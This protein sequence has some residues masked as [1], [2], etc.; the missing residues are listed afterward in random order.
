MARKPAPIPDPDHPDEKARRRRL[1]MVTALLLIGL[2]VYLIVAAFLVAQLE[3]PH[4]L[5]ELAIYVA[6]GLVWAFPLKRLVKGLGK[7]SPASIKP[8]QG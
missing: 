7:P 4:W 2:P 6:L 5:I 8:P 3:R 1:A